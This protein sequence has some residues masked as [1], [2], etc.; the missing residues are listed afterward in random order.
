MLP[1]EIIRK[2]RD[3]N[4]LSAEEIQFVVDGITRNTLSEAQV[5]AFA[6]AVFFQGMDM[7]ERVALTRGMMNSGDV[8]SWDNLG[9][10]GPVVDKHSSGGVGDKISLMLAPIVAACGAY[11][12]M[13]AGRGLGHT[14]GTVDKLEAIPGYNT[15]PSDEQFRAIVK[16]LGFAIIGQTGELAPA[17]KRL[18]GIRDV[19]AT[20]ES[21]PLITASILSKKLAAGLDAL[22]MD[23]KCGNGAFC[24]TF[25]MA[26]ELSES[27]V[28]VAN[29]A[30]TATNALITD[31]NQVL[32]NT[33]GNSVETI[34]VI[35]YLTIKEARE[36]RQHEIT[37][38]L[39]A[40][41]VLLGKLAD[42]IEEARE[43]AEDALESG[44]A[45]EKFAQMVVELG[46]PADLIEK[47]ESH[48]PLAEVTRDVY[49]NDAGVITELNTREIGLSVV[50]LGGGR[51][52]PT[53]DIDHAVG[54]SCIRGLGDDVD[55]NTPFCR[56]HARNEDQADAAEVAIKSAV[57]V[58]ETSP[59]INNI[60][61]E[62]IT[63]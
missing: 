15:A 56:I 5:G 19:T 46:G 54:L 39:A 18:Y 29:G 36:P 13:I 8:L 24:D 55:S 4:K 48:M 25:E 21:V 47:K 23:I 34:E 1:Q 50:T 10:D 2:K 14:G 43:K 60:V 12:P 61:M 49:L 32:G 52:S 9:L 45:A 63:S 40:E 6:M 62:R 38:A 57:T 41:M 11:V 35:D 44:R 28:A 59:V 37:M 17:D 27:I 22:V 33:A 53:D 3:G 20:V 58:G 30:D 16:K 31:M 42:T 7:D 51:K 26:K